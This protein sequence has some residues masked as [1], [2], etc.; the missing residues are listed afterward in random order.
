[1]RDGAHLDTPLT[2]P[3]GGHGKRSRARHGFVRSSRE[4]DPERGALASRL[5]G[6]GG[7]PGLP[8]PRGPTD[9]PMDR[10]RW[11]LQEAPRARKVA[12][13]DPPPR[14]RA[15]VRHAPSRQGRASRGRPGA[16]RAPTISI[17]LGTH[18]HVLPGTGGQAASVMDEALQRCDGVPVGVVEA[19]YRPG[20]H[21][22]AHVHP[23]NQLIFAVG[24]V[25]FEPAP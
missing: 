3:I 25:G 22:C 4:G 10:D 19:G 1:M 23:A 21:P 8:R 11:V 6:E 24:A 9:A 12:R 20:L 5:A 13:E 2:R 17:T 15:H 14:P 18:S 7:R 16:P